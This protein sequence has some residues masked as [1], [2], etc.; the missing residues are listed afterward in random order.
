MSKLHTI[1]ALQHVRLHHDWIFTTG[2][3][4]PT[5]QQVFV[6]D[7]I[8]TFPTPAYADLWIKSQ[9]GTTEQALFKGFA[10]MGRDFYNDPLSLN[11]WAF[12]SD[13]L[14]VPPVTWEDLTNSAAHDFARLQ[15]HTFWKWD[16]KQLNGPRKQSFKSLSSMAPFIELLIASEPLV[17]S[18]GRSLYTYFIDHPSENPKNILGYA[19]VLL[20]ML[21]SIGA[22]TLDRIPEIAM[23]HV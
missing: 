20:T 15:W 3:L 23:S 17:Q 11:L 21:Q 14:T 2:I 7:Q 18:L 9:Q 13:A 16:G 6:A 4:S 8:Y 22:G 1:R 12:W 19:A 10:N 5:A